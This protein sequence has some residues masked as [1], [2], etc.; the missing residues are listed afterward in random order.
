MDTRVIK[1]A[2]FKFEVKF[3]PWGCWGRLEAVMASE[4][5]K[6]AVRCNMH[7]DTRVIMVADVKSEVIWPLRLFE[8]H[9]G[10]GGCWRQYAH[11]YQRIQGC[12][13]QIWGHIRY[14]LILWTILSCKI[15]IW[16]RSSLL[17]EQLNISF[18]RALQLLR[19][20]L[21]SLQYVYLLLLHSFLVYQTPENKRAMAL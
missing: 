19:S 14:V 4:A 5:T 3:D 7:M 10:L 15:P 8:G 12:W 18:Y 2:D 13:F 21:L 6:I 11:G 17:R 1:V 16:R 20:S 9:H